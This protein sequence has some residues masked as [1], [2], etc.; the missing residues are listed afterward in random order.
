MKLDRRLLRRARAARA[1]LALTVG[2]GLLAGIVLVGQ[3][4]VLSRVIGQAFLGGRSLS[5][6]ASLLAVLVVLALVRAATDGT[7]PPDVACELI[8]AIAKAAGV[9]EADEL[10]K[11]LEAMEAKLYGDLA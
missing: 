3:A 5:T 10:R 9:E 11:R 8:S 4:R 1:D 7:L 6:Q 2:L